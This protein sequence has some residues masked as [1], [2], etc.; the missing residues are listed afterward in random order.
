MTKAKKILSM[1]NKMAQQIKACTAKLGNPSSIP[2]TK[3]VE[4]ENTL[5]QAVH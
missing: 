5:S 1:A 4:R 2:G 3:T